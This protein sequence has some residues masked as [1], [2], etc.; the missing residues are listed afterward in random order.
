MTSTAGPIITA[1][2]VWP[3]LEI[4][5]WAD[6]CA[7]LHMLTQ[8]VGKLRL[9]LSPMQNHWWN[10][11]FYVTERGLTT[12]AMPYRD[13]F[14]SVDFDFISHAV[15]VRTSDG[16][17]REI[18]LVEQPVSAFYRDYLRVLRSLDVEVAIMAR[19]VEVDPA[20]PFAKDMTHTSYDR[21]AVTRWWQALLQVNRVLQ[22]FRGRFEGKAS[23]VHFFW[24][25]F[26]LAAT[27]FSGRSAPQHPG[28]A[29]NTPDYVMREAYSR[30]CSSCGFWPGGG[31]QQA[32]FYSYAYPEP[33][34]YSTARVLPEAAYYDQGIREFL[35]PYDA[36]RTAESPDDTLLSFLQ[37]TYDAAS[38]LGGWDREI[39]DRSAKDFRGG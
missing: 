16:G 36:V 30:E 23:P 6:T 15:I 34:G 24:G 12:S 20:V 7:T 26:D 28:G 37:S 21:E 18:P 11:A 31:G 27:R 2:D 5:K 8:I 22:L 3:E 1:P 33:A 39:L 17:S 10:V 19:P 14:V 38:D 4:D 35:L 9:A 13:R 25:S 29:P 32:A